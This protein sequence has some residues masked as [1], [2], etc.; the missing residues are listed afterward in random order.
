MSD[1]ERLVQNCYQNATLREAILTAHKQLRT[2]RPSLEITTIVIEQLFIELK[3][4]NFPIVDKQQV[5]QWLDDV[6][7]GVLTLALTEGRRASD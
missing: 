5:S 2:G 7:D 3:A 4:L 6:M 1:V